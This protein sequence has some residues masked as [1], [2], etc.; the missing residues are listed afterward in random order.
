[1]TDTLETP[2]QSLSLREAAEIEGGRLLLPPITPEPVEP[3]FFVPVDL[4][5]RF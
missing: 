1:M 2:L 4:Q 5:P 3:P